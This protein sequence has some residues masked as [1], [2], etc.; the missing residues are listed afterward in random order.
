[1]L[2]LITPPRHHRAIGSSQG[3][4]D[5]YFRKRLTRYS[6]EIE[7]H[8]SI[9]PTRSSFKQELPLRPWTRFGSGGTIKQIALD[10]VRT[11]LKDGKVI[12]LDTAKNRYEADLL[13]GNKVGEIVVTPEGQ[14]TEGPKWIVE[15]L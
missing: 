4:A 12:K 14:F 7:S 2:H 11:E 6:S 8:P 13:N 15:P 5:F 1:M 3:P 10:E 9:A